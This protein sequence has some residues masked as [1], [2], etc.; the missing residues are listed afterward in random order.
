M[1]NPFPQLL[2]YANP[3]RILRGRADQF[4]EA[5]GLDRARLTGWAFAQAVLSGW[6]SYEDHRRGWEYFIACAEI[7]ARIT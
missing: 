3:E 2:Q 6:W 7:L 1:T 4:A 5:L